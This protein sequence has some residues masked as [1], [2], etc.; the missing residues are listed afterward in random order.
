MDNVVDM[1]QPIASVEFPHLRLYVL[2][3]LSLLADT[4]RRELPWFTGLEGD[5][6][7]EGVELIWDVL[8]ED[9][10]IHEATRHADGTVLVVGEEARRLEVCGQ[11]FVAIFDRCREEVRSTSSWGSLLSDPE[12]SR[13]V[14]F[15][16]D[17][18]VAMVNNWGFPRFEEPSKE[19]SPE[20]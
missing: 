7:V 14:E 2:E 13:L 4:E 12:W 10:N 15:A 20:A 6:W 17:A 5:A 16:T 9:R 11:L 3:M 1:V 19:S 8:I 18:L